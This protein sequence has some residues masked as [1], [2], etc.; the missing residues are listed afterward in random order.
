VENVINNSAFSSNMNDRTIQCGYAGADIA[1]LP[2]HVTDAALDIMSRLPREATLELH[3]SHC[4][5]NA[6]AFDPDRYG[7]V[8]VSDER[9]V[10]QAV[11]YWGGVAF[12]MRITGNLPPG[13]REN[14][15]GYDKSQLEVL[16]TPEQSKAQDGLFGYPWL[17]EGQRSGP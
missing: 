1:N 4:D 10:V 12:N 13:T 14:G 8:Y 11:Y 7:H 15:F 6:M 3:R 17:V 16:V 9:G 5:R 2:Q